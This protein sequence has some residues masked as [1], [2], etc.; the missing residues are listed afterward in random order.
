LEPDQDNAIRISSEA[1]NIAM[2]LRPSKSES[3]LNQTETHY[4]EWLRGLG[5]LWI[6]IQCIR[7]NLSYRCDYTPDFWALNQSGLRAID[8]KGRHIWEDSIIKMKLAARLFPFVR[9][10]K[11]EKDGLVWKHTEFPT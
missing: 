9:F 11:A 6:G 1:Y 2:G 7:L 5:D 3:G 4:L 8:V 10:I